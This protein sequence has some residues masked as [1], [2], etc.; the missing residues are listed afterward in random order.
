MIQSFKLLVRKAAPDL[1][2]R[3][4]TFY[5]NYFKDRKET[6]E[7]IF[8]I[9]SWQNEE[10]RSGGGSTLEATECLRRDLPGLLT[11]LGVQSL[12]DAPCGDFNWMKDL[13]LWGEIAY[14]GF[15]IVD[16]LIAAN[17]ERYKRP[18]VAFDK[19][20]IVVD[21]LPPADMILCRD[22][23]IHLSNRDVARA[24]RMFRKSGATW[25]ALSQSDW[26][27]SNVDTVTGGMRR[28]NFHLAPFGFPTPE[29]IIPD[30]SFADEARWTRGELPTPNQLGVWR[31][32]A[33]PI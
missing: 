25:V 16:E 10:S 17:C 21:V 11:A 3:A 19:A 1:Y 32:S 18:G 12:N 28:I 26:C 6:F 13:K 9:N 8:K 22:A 4:A 14:H 29:A 2:G 27:K 20:D 7:K 5:S 24:L 33:L 23:M 15:D 31:I 30:L